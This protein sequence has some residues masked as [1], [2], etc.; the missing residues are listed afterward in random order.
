MSILQ[1]AGLSRRAAQLCAAFRDFDVK[2]TGRID[3]TFLEALIHLSVDRELTSSEAQQLSNFLDGITDAREN[4]EYEAFVGWLYAPDDS[5]MPEL[6]LSRVSRPN[7]QGQRPLSGR[8]L[9]H[10]AKPSEARTSNSVSLAETRGAGYLTPATGQGAGVLPPRP[11]TTWPSVGSARSSRLTPEPGAVTSPRRPKSNEPRYNFPGSRARSGQGPRPRPKSGQVADVQQRSGGSRKDYRPEEP[12]KSPLPHLVS[13][14]GLARRFGAKATFF[15]LV[16]C[17]CV[18][19]ALRASEFAMEGDDQNQD[20]TLFVQNLLKEMQGRF[21]T[22]S[23]SIIN[24]IDDMGSRIDD[25]EKSIS[26]LIQEAGVEGD[27]N[28]AASQA[29]PA[30]PS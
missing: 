20:L 4:V 10:V 11:A 27:A 22:M 1:A 28:A 26:E 2:R 15:G 3:R 6:V 25:L 21:Q 18:C 7:L 16:L 19:A 14:A 30:R 9:G 13:P 5:Y 24:R 8:T 23:D 29:A 17:V 12:F